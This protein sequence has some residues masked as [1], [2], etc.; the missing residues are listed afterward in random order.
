M[1]LE[2]QGVDREI[3]GMDPEF[4]STDPEFLNTNPELFKNPDI[5]FTDMVAIERVALWQT[6]N[7]LEFTW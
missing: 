2:I 5:K 4:Q 1:N 3:Q 7:K 6:Y